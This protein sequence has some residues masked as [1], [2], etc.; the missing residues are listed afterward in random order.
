MPTFPD[1]REFFDPA[2]LLTVNGTE[3]RIEAPV[4]SEHLRIRKFFIS[5]DTE[6]SDEQHMVENLKLLGGSLDP[7]TGVVTGG[8]AE[9]MVSDGVSWDELMH[10]GSTAMVH[11][12]LG[13]EAAALFWANGSAALSAPPEPEK[14]APSKAAPARRAPAKKAAPK[15]APAKTAARKSAK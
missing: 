13:E 12:A 3:Y 11:F 1:L 15:K 10:V 4:V 5:A 2:L 14:A 9:Q 8:V 7:D 6:L